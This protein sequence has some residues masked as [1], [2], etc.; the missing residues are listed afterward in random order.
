MRLRRLAAALP[1][2][3]AILGCT[4]PDTVEH[5]PDVAADDGGQAPLSTRYEFDPATIETLDGTVLAVQP[6]QRMRGTRYGVRA[7][8]DAD[9]ERFYVY[10][11][12]QG[13]LANRGLLLSA[14]DEIEVRGSVV[15]TQGQRV[16]IATEVVK[17]GKTF[18]LRDASG[19][20]Q[21]RS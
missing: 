11:G 17:D 13:F 10:L 14:G 5:E 6:F 20:P 9:G 4:Q 16:V 8:L 18:A 15:G 7:R 12:P 19:R 1:L 2:A 21:W 3:L